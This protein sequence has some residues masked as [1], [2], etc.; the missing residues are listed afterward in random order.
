MAS[1]TLEKVSQRLNS[2]FEGTGYFGQASLTLAH[3]SAV[4]TYMKRFGVKRKIYINPL[5]SLNEKFYREGLLFQCLY[6]NKKRDVF[7]AGGRYDSLIRDFVPKTQGR[8][9]ERHAVG[10]NMA[11]ERLVVSML[12]FQRTASTK[13]LKNS[14]SESRGLWAT[15]RVWLGILSMHNIDLRLISSATYW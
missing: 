4:V 5:G 15:R 7:A 13:Y 11:W 12:R 8:A 1:D 9:S 6:D 2:I 14:D 3:I 10:F